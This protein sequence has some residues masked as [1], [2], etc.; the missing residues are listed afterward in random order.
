MSI[1]MRLEPKYVGD[2]LAHRPARRLLQL[3]PLLVATP[4]QVVGYAHVEPVLLEQIA[5]DADALMATLQM[6]LSAA[7]QLMAHAAP[8]V[9][10]GTFSSDMVEALG[11]FMSE[12]SEISFTLMP[13]VVACR[14]HNADYA[15]P[16]PE[17]VQP[18]VF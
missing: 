14:H 13:L 4:G 1:D 9:E 6:G 16:H 3:L 2:A 15:P 5:D 8:E 17:T 7:A 11:W 18:V 12:V 10:D